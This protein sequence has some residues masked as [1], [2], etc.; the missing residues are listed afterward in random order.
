ML[1]KNIKEKISRKKVECI[2]HKY[3]IEL[4]HYIPG[5]VR[6]RI[7]QWEDREQVVQ[8][9]LNDMRADCDLTLVEFTPVTGSVVIYYDCEASKLQ[10]TQNRWLSILQKYS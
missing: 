10:E 3:G 4:Q 7:L 2:L 8:N 6:L 9:L 5:R 1:L